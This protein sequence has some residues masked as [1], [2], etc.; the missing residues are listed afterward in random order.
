MPKPEKDYTLEIEAKTAVDEKIEAK[1]VPIYMERLEL[2]KSQKERLVKEFEAEFEAIKAERD[3]EHLESKWESLENQ[4]QGKM[5]EDSRMQFNLNRNITKPIVDRVANFIK[6]GFFKSDPIYSVSPRPEFD[7]EGG[8]E[9]A[10]KQQDFLDCK[11][12]NLPFRAPVGKA[13]KSATKLGTGIL[14]ITHVIKRLPRKREERYQGN[15]TTVGL[16]PKT[17]LSVIRNTGLEEFLSNWPKAR[18]DYPGLVTQLEEGKEINIIAEYQD[19]IYNDPLPQFVELKNFYVRLACE[20][21]EGLKETKLISEIKNYSWWELQQEEKKDKFYDIDELIKDAKDPEKKISNYEKETFDILENTFFFKLKEDDKD[22]VRII[23]WYAVKEKVVIGSVLYPYDVM[24]YIPFY[25]SDE[26]TGFY[27]PGLAE[28]TTDSHIA[29]SVILNLALG[30]AYIRNTITPITDDQDVIDQFLE[31]RFTHGIPI[32][33]KSGSVDFVQKY[34]QNLD[35][36]GLLNIMQFMKYTDEEVTQSS[37]GMSGKESPFDPTAPASKT[38]ALLKMA[39]I[40]IDEYIASITPSFNQIAYVLLQLYYQMS[41]EG[42]KYKVRP[43]RVVG[44]NPFAELSR[45][46]MIARTNIQAQAY[47]YDFDKL[48]AKKEDY[49]LYQILRVEPVFNQNPEAV[50]HLLRTV[51]KSWSQ[52]WSNNIEKLL[53]PMQEF[54][55]MQLKTAIAAVGVYVAGVIQQSQTTGLAPQFDPRQL[56]ALIAQMQKE[57]MTPPT[58]EEMAAREEK[59]KETVNG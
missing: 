42:R 14:K 46:D 32:Q 20:G 24:E 22:P 11:L 27:Q 19:T 58:P 25:I 17:G 10:S 16:D 54:R 8:D 35:L 38:I 51:V 56:L 18:E 4:Y 23:F 7:K 53:P 9:V 57:S 41:T 5:Q 39:G 31:K 52:K 6:Q 55:Q 3:A 49:A 26:K 43:E 44:N 1:E 15:P 48:E 28:F 59:A 37:S 34:M 36:G 12:D 13:I 50:Y 45:N 33:G 2:D 21:Y 29:Q 40:G 30:G 47:A